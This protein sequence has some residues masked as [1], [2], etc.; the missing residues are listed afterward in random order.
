MSS[1]SPDTDCGKIR[2]GPAKPPCTD[3]G[4]CSASMVRPIASVA[5]PSEM[6]LGRTKENV[7]ATNG[8]SWLIESG[9]VPGPKCEKAESGTMVTTSLEIEAPVQALARA[10]VVTPG[11]CWVRS[12][13]SATS[14]AVGAVVADAA[15]TAEVS[16]GGPA[17]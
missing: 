5:W 14:A 8:P 3:T 1:G 10:V 6:P 7:V 16:V 13:P 11:T 12:A 9:V 17:T 15:L 2:A 4:T